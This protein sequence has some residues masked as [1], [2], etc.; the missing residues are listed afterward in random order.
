MLTVFRV[1]KSL[2][3]TSWQPMKSPSCQMPSR[4]VQSPGIMLLRHCQYHC[5]MFVPSSW[6]GAS[7][8]GVLKGLR[9]GS[10]TP[11]RAAPIAA[12][13]SSSRTGRNVRRGVVRV[14]PNG[15]Q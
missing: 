15:G 12:G 7:V 8:H 14:S 1:V 9:P 4:R 5:A 3:A 10:C 11:L 2:A 13:M 6:R